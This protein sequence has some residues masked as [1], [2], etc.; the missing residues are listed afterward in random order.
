M[1]PTR[2]QKPTFFKSPAEFREWLAKNHE[3]KAELVV[4]FYKRHT[5]KASLTWPESVD[6]ALSVGWIDGIRRSLGADSYTIRFTPRKPG[7]TWSAVNITRVAALEKEGRMRP[8]GRAAFAHKRESRSG[9][10]SYEQRS[11]ELPAK[12]AVEFRKHKTAWM[13]FQS[14][15]PGYRKTSMWYIVSA[16][17]EETREKRLA[18][19][20]DCSARG[21]TLPGLRP[22]K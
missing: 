21:V 18:V 12:Y 17:K 22:T 3:T 20:I 4:G 14:L 7:S 11:P 19:L 16:K 2:A 8:A 10:Y 13:Y 15:P 5:G 6:E 9:I 1:P